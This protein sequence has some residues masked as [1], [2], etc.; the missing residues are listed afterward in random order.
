MANLNH[1]VLLGNLTR[2]AELKYTNTGT[3]VS[4]FSLAVNRRIKKGD[5]WTDEA[6][7]FDIVIWGKTAENLTQYLLK[8]KQVAIEGELR[9]SRWDDKETGK[10]RSKV[11]IS[12]TNVQLLGGN[13]SG[14]S[15]EG[16][17]P[18]KGNNT[19]Q[20]S[21]EREDFEDDIPF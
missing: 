5:V 14:G 4:K 17:A 10:S 3:A 15:S 9:Q 16:S 19:N 18:F 1:V 21:Q 13:R 12:A 8:G 6:N 7:F 11:E 2:D 20:F